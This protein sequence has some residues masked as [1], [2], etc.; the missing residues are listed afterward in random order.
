MVLSL[1]LILYGLDV[2][3]R[4]LVIVFSFI[5]AFYFWRRR[6]ELEMK[7][8]RMVFLGQGLFIFCYG[9]TRLLFLFQLYFKD[10][11]Y[12]SIF[13]DPALSDLI[14]KVSTAIG[15][16]SMVFLLV[17]IETYLVKSRYVFS[18]IALVGCVLSLVL[19]VETARIV[20]Y[21]ALPLAMIGI[22]ALY[23]YLFFKSSGEL[24]KKVSWSLN[25][26]IIFGIGVVIDTEYGKSI[27]SG[28]LGIV[29]PFLAEVL[30]IVGLAIYT[31][32][33]IKD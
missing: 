12:V 17:V 27:L 15:I 21:I 7:S 4:T 2:A 25:G 30:M 22:I 6:S 29:P 10:D 31:Y 20:T 26:F 33:N 24:R 5:F 3:A 1:T 28:W 19:P 18:L 11:Y 23:A 14:W 13:P 16:L 8:S 32:Y 9:I